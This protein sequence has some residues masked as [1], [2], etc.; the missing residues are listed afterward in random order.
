[1]MRRLC[2][3][4]FLF[5]S[6]TSSPHEQIKM[7]QSHWATLCNFLGCVNRLLHQCELTLRLDSQWMKILIGSR[8][9]LKL[10]SCNWLHALGCNWLRAA[11][12]LRQVTNRVRELNLHVPFSRAC[13]CRG[14]RSILSSFAGTP[15]RDCCAANAHAILK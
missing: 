3:P 2:L 6:F 4:G 15:P 13:C 7:K 9:N 10:A 5:N 1:M 12:L 11:S 14:L 8:Q